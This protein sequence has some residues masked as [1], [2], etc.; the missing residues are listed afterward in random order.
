[1]V[2]PCDEAD[3]ALFHASTTITLGDGATASFW[4]C[5]WTGFGSLKTSFPKLFVHSRRNNR[6]VRDALANNTWIADL[7]HGNMVHLWEEAVRLH[8][9][10]RDRQIILQEGTQDTINWNLE[11]SGIYSARSAYKAQFQGHLTSEYKKM[12]W[13]TWAPGRLKF[14]L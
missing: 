2:L 4:H 1:M 10:I 3:R 13:A 11:A 12:I 14:F 6:S 7:A 8:R 5:S 9:W